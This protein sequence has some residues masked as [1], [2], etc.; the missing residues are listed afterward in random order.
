MPQYWELSDALRT[1]YVLQHVLA[2]LELLANNIDNDITRNDGITE[3]IDIIYTTVVN[4]LL[5]GSEL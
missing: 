4:A 2:D 3:A 5:L 1:S